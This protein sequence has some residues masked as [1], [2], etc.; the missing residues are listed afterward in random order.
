M[1]Q[2]DRQENVRVG[3]TLTL[4]VDWRNSIKLFGSTGVYSRTGSDFSA[5]EIAWQFRWDAGL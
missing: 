3:G 2:D 1:E 4:P 5:V